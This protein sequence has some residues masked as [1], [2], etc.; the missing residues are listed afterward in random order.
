MQ[1]STKYITILPPLSYEMNIFVNLNYQNQIQISMSGLK[2]NGRT[3]VK[4]AFF[5]LLAIAFFSCIFLFAGAQISTKTMMPDV[6]YPFLD[7][8][9]E[10]AKQ[11]YPRTHAFEHRVAAQQ[12]NLK[13]MKLGWF[14]VFT[15]SFLYSPNNSTTL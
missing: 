14:D 5:K 8:L 4:T 2:A 12:Q 3:T 1:F 9:I 13:K 6:S 7:K 10:A 11:N 15:F